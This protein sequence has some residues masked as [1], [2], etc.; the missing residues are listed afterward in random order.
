MIASKPK[1]T[2]C[3]L[4][5][6][7]MGQHGDAFHENQVEE[8]NNLAHAELK[9]ADRRLK[10]RECIIKFNGVHAN[11]KRCGFHKFFFC[12]SDQTV[13]DILSSYWAQVEL[14]LSSGIC[15]YFV[16]FHMITAFS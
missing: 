5:L 2:C 16:T 3:I 15:K 7:N 11:S 13:D 6:G 1:T 12:I 4:L 8:A 9:K 10:V 14:R